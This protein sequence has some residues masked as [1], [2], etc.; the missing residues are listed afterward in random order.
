[1]FI[2]K[3]AIGAATKVLYEWSD[4]NIDGL[5]EEMLRAAIPYINAYEY[6]QNA[7]RA[8]A[9][10][11][12]YNFPDYCHENIKD[13]LGRMLPGSPYDRGRYDASNEI[14]SI[15]IIPIS[16]QHT[17]YAS[18]YLVAAYQI[19]GELAYQLDVLDT[20]EVQNVLDYFSCKDDA[21]YPLPFTTPIHEKQNIWK[22]IEQ[23]NGNGPI[24]RWH[25]IWNCPISVK[26]S[27]K[28]FQYP[29]VEVTL[30]TQWPEEAFL[31]FYV[32]LSNLPKPQ[33]EIVNKN[34]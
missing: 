33:E 20:P 15:P 18:D 32:E 34:V 7:M 22:P 17:F 24:I 28:D 14:L 2:S 3:K 1:M 25:K 10:S 21:K 27:P 23:Y 6:G 12:A 29:W 5:P 26:L 16:D 8:E 11:V 13:D 9:A 30:T 4:Q 31:P 19:V